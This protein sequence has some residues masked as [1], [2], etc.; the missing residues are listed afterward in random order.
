MLSLPEQARSSLSES[1]S[2]S[3]IIASSF[4]EFPNQIKISYY[5]TLQEEKQESPPD[6]RL[7]SVPCTI[8]PHA[9]QLVS[10]HKDIQPN[11]KLFRMRGL[12]DQLMNIHLKQ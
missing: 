6:G 5:Q 7:R 2:D 12:L 3:G 10:Y 11:A 1:H 4:R 9:V 8:I